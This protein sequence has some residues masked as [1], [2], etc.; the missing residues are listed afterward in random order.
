MEQALLQ[1]I[2]QDPADNDAWLVLPRVNP[3]FGITRA[4]RQYA[5]ASAPCDPAALP[6]AEAEPW[7]ELSPR[8]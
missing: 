2:H 5:P 6:V 8:G 3:S 7:I 1:A 4:A